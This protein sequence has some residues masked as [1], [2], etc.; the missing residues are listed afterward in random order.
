MS[1]QSKRIVPKTVTCIGGNLHEVEIIKAVLNKFAKDHDVD[2]TVSNP[3][4]KASEHTCEPGVLHIRFWSCPDTGEASGNRL[5]KVYGINLDNGQPDALKYSGQGIEIKDDDGVTIAEYLPGTLFILFDL[6]HGPN[7]KKLL[8]RVLDS[9]SKIYTN[10]PEDFEKALAEIKA[11]TERQYVELCQSL[12]G[13]QIEVTKRKLVEVDESIRKAQATMISH[14]RTRKEIQDHI[15]A[16]IQLGSSG[17]TT[18]FQ[19]QFESLCS[20]SA[21]G[22]IKV[23]N[24]SMI[25]PVGQ[26][27]IQYGDD[28]YDIGQFDVVINTSGENGG[29]TCINRTPNSTKNDCY[30]PH[31]LSS[32]SCCLGNISQIIA[33]LISVGDYVNVVLIM[34][35][36]LRSYSPS[37]PY[38]RIQHWPTKPS[39]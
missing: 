33:K 2:V 10:S 23:T 25:I 11:R 18:T 21:T 27:D 13:L 39:N 8:T 31:V 19:S 17:I 32:G 4:G 24:S 35:D 37:N 7:V 15:K 14:T 26:I 29:V 34:T 22:Q 3:H 20:I 28:V 30:H 6:P 16:L 1:F 38:A 36:F 5:S 9:F 12:T